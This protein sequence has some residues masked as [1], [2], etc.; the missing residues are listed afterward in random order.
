MVLSLSTPAVSRILQSENTSDIFKP[1]SCVWEDLS[2]FVF[3][4]LYFPPL[5]GTESNGSIITFDKIT[6]EGKT[7]LI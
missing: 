6:D 2:D 7:G 5:E 4:D 1:R 3:R